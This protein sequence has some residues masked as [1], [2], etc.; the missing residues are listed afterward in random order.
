MGTK[1]VTRPGDKKHLIPL[2]I[3]KIHLSM[4]E[5]NSGFHRAQRL[6]PCPHRGLRL[7]QGPPLPASRS[8]GKDGIRDPKLGWLF[9]CPGKVK[10][11]GPLPETFVLCVWAESKKLSWMP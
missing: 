3:S 10:A 7:P 5:H 4:S 6:Q 2:S 9:D 8:H 1:T 11:C